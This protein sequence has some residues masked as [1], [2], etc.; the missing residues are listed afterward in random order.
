[1]KRSFLIIAKELSEK[2]SNKPWGCFETSGV[3]KEGI[4]EFSIS[5]NKALVENLR[6]YGLEGTTDEELVQTFFLMSRMVPKSW[7]E[8]EEAINPQAT[9]HLTNEA[10]RFVA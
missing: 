10:N 6:N 5:Y 4:I 3:T 8:D 2:F 9:P 1:M 7:E